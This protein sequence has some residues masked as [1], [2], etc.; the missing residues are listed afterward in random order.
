MSNICM[1]IGRG[2]LISVMNGG[3]TCMYLGDRMPA[4]SELLLAL[5]NLLF[6]I[7]ILTVMTFILALDHGLGFTPT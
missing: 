4:I 7:S 6:E 1:L 2:L 3:I 5:S